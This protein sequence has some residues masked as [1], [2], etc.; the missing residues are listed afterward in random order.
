MRVWEGESVSL[1]VAVMTTKKPPRLTPFAEMSGK[2]DY[3]LP[4]A[5]SDVT[6]QETCMLLNPHAS[7]M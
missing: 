7:P 1:L 3:F 6:T 2:C 4:E 5:Q